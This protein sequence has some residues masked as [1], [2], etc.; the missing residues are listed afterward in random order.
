MRM[1]AHDSTANATTRKRK[2]AHYVYHVV[3]QVQLDL[4]QNQRHAKVAMRSTLLASRG[5]SCIFAM[6]LPYY[7]VGD[8]RTD[9]N[10]RG[11]RALGKHLRASM[12]AG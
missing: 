11:F 12:R 10:R 2:A 6:E 3:H 8:V 5:R 4:Q 1:Y 7:L 9:R